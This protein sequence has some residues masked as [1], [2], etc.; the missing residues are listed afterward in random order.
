MGTSHS[1]PSPRKAP[2]PSTRVSATTSCVPRP[3]TLREQLVPC[4]PLARPL[5][6][7][8]LTQKHRGKV[9]SVAAPDLAARARAARRRHQPAKRR[10][11]PLAPHALLASRPPQGRVGGKFTATGHA[12]ARLQ[13]DAFPLHRRLHGRQRVLRDHPGAHR[14]AP[15]ARRCVARPPLLAAVAA[16]PGTGRAPCPPAPGARCALCW[17]VAPVSPAKVE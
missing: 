16:T 5:G 9:G 17:C 10:G 14:A 7:E 2:R 1:Q 11:A 12:E 4:S 13:Q 8:T 15:A 6:S 3:H